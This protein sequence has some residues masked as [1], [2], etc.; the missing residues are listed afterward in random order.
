MTLRHRFAAAGLAAALTLTPI[1]G[2]TAS[3]LGATVAQAAPSSSQSASSAASWLATQ[4]ADG[5]CYKSPYTG[6]ADIS[7]TANALIG[8]VAG[9]NGTAAQKVNGWLQTN[10]SLATKPGQL[11]IV[12]IAA[13][14]IGDDPSNY[15]GR[16]L[17][18]DITEAVD[19]GEGTLGDPY[20]DSLALIAIKGASDKVPDD[21]VA[22]LVKQ[23]NAEG[24]FFFG[25]GSSA[26]PDPDATGVAIQA[27][28]GIE[29]DDAGAA[30][31]KAV[32]WAT[33]N[34]KSAGY[35]DSYSPANTTS[36]IGSALQEQGKDVSKA[37]AWMKGQQ[38]K[39]GSLPA[40]LGGTDGDAYATAQSLLLLG[41]VTLN[42][43]SLQGGEPT[44]APTSTST[45]PSPTPTTTG[46]ATATATGST[47]SMPAGSDGSG[48]K[49]S[50]LPST[51]A[52]GP[53]RAGELGAL[54]LGFVAVGTVGGALALRARRNS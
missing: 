42:T 13:E 19:K 53:S 32:A 16:D 47:T 31:S 27:L 4:L 18:G 1:A 43:V 45:T 3:T 5:Q 15:G 8:L 22:S 41:G 14:A 33:K 39:D 48:D 6:A 7:G 11:A 54:A 26:W 52:E 37:L 29:G 24:E 23:Q 50:A 51:G 38:L 46:T 21:L 30:L 20:S 49:P 10:I 25:S 17:I 34:Q 40:E 12:A 36:L 2:V 9:G 28:D 44:T 35:W